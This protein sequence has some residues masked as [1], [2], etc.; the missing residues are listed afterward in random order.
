MNVML[1]VPTETLAL[2]TYML[3]IMFEQS[4]AI[5]DG[6]VHRGGPGGLELTVNGELWRVGLSPADIFFAQGT[7][8][9]HRLCYWLTRE[10]ALTKSYHPI[11][12]DLAAGAVKNP[13]EVSWLQ[14]LLDAADLADWH[15]SIVIGPRPRSATEG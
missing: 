9:D 2:R 12:H 7:I 1:A 15:D 13:G 3:L 11:S 4:L 6:A 8:G 10:G 14:Q 5:E